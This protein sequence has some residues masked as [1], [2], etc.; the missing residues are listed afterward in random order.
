MNGAMASVWPVHHGPWLVHGIP[1]TGSHFHPFAHSF[2]A[3]PSPLWL[4][5]SLPHL[6][7]Q[8]FVATLP[9]VQREQ[10][11]ALLHAHRVLA[12]NAAAAA[13]GIEPGAKRATALALAPQLTTSQPDALRERAVLHT[14]AHVALAFT[15]MVVLQEQGGAQG[16]LLELRASLRYFG[17]VAALLK[18]LHAA[19]A[20][21]GLAVQ[22]ASAPTPQGAWLLAQWRAGL[23][24]GPHSQQLDALR[25]LLDAVPTTLLG[26]GGEHAQALQAMG[27]TT[28]GGLR[29][30]PREGLARRF[31]PALL[32]QIDRARG[33]QPDPRQAFV[34]AAVFETKLELHE[35]ADDA[36]QLLHGA[37]V[38]LQRLVAWARAQQ[39]RIARF[40]LRL[41][42][43]QRHRQTE[44]VNEFTDLPIALALASDDV[45]HLQG[46]LRE[47]LQRLAL[48]APTL[49]LHLHCRE[50]EHRAAPSGELFPTQASQREGLARLL[51]R[52]QA[53]LGP[54]QVQRLVLVQD[55][56]PER[57][58]VLLPVQPGVNT[59]AAHVPA[60]LLQAPQHD[61]LPLHRPVWLLHPAQA[62][63]ERQTVPLFEGRPL[64]V[65]AGPERIET[66]WWDGDMAL[67]DYYIAQTHAGALVWV[68]RDRLPGP[69]GPAS[70]PGPEGSGWYLH[71][72]F[73]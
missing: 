11:V 65:L 49:E 47:R 59:P 20:P 34:P 25:T 44:Q 1:A 58:T 41:R 9:V 4:A 14:V 53:R 72:R 7:L 63:H 22:A 18:Q 55:H 32:L 21:L 67:R 15:P 19:L 17:G 13:L 16:V 50:L 29:A 52:L 31:G 48:P 42:H 35:R 8:A 39:A 2:I 37:A 26:Q 5:L 36:E 46:L 38:L 3:M 23:A 28:L 30:Q 27:L 43:E 33:E 70:Q 64:Q 73:G 62:L 6:P 54:E 51:E 60:A 40:T 71:G 68:Y 12:A 69:P 45:A 66:G 57:G 10:P 24:L 61:P 56:R